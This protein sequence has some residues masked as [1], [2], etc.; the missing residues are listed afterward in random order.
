MPKFTK[1]LHGR[2]DHDAIGGL[3]YASRYIKQANHLSRFGKDIFADDSRSAPS[4][5]VKKLTL[6][7][8]EAIEAA[9]GRTAAEFDT[10]TLIKVMDQLE[11]AG[12]A[13]KVDLTEEEMASARAAISAMKPPRAKA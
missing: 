5:A 8:L 9:E 6:E 3:Y 13:F 7:I 10:P 1:L 11:E 2:S 12:R 4:E